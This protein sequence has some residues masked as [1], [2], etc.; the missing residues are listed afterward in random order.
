MRNSSS[1]L[2]GNFG[3]D[4]CI[5]NQRMNDVKGGNQAGECK[6]EFCMIGENIDLARA[7]YHLTLD[8]NLFWKWTC[9]PVVQRNSTKTD[10]GFIHVELAQRLFSNHTD[11]R[12]GTHE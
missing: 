8:R 1:H 11:K 5:G 7:L 6:I 10:K 2:T 3:G 9:Q 12:I 4:M